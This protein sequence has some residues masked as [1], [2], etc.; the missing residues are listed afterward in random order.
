[1]RGLRDGR[2]KGKIQEEQEVL[3]NCVFEEVS[4]GFVCIFLGF[5]ISFF[6]QKY[7]NDAK[8]GKWDKEEGEVDPESGAESS[9]S[10]SETA[11]EGD[12]NTPKVDP[13]KWTVRYSISTQKILTSLFFQ[14]LT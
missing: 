6:S 11:G 2:F 5:L 8:R 10:P 3:F 13:L 4:R 9:L 7:K 1:M 14:T 12:D